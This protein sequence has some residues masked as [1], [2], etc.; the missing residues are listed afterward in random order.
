MTD[1]NECLFDN[2]GCDH[3]CTNTNGSFQCSCST[4]YNLCSNAYCIGNVRTC[5]N[6]CNPL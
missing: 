1:V 3:D 2:G 6:D 5:V 4:G